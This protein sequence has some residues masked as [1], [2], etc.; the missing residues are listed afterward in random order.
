MKRLENIL[1]GI[2]DGAAAEDALREACLIARTFGATLHLACAVEADD[3]TPEFRAGAYDARQISDA[4]AAEAA[5]QGVSV[6]PARLIRSGAA[7]D[8]LLAAA[9]EIDAD[10]IVLGAGTKTTLDRVLLGS[11]A[12]RVAREAQQ[13]VWL[14]RPG[15][16]H[17]DLRTLLCAV[18]ASDP[19]R[20]AL[21]TATFLARTFVARLV[22]LSVVPPGASAAAA[23]RPKLEQAARALDLHAIDHEFMERQGKPAVEI[24]EATRE[25]GCDVLLLGMAARTAVASWLRPNTAEKVLRVVP[26]SVL[27][28][29]AK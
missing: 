29:R 21:G 27:T 13:P 20:E 19:A 16:V 23:A 14:V 1:V 24:V 2:D 8:V 11:V 6:A 4:L 9:T 28:L 5:A 7:A 25:T 3:S 22:I 26:C 10:L 18:D 17:R 15:K 12:E